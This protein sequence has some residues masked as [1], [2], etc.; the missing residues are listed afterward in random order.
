MKKSYQFDKYNM[1]VIKINMYLRAIISHE[2]SN[3]SE[4]NILAYNVSDLIEKIKSQLNI[5]DIELELL[6]KELKNN[7]YQ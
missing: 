2:N 5:S 1:I 3:F 6:R 4:I 7:N